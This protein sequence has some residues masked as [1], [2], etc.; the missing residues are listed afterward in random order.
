M[1]KYLYTKYILTY[2]RRNERETGL[3]RH[4]RRSNLKTQVSLWKPMKCFPSS[5]SNRNLKTQQSPVILD[6]CLRKTRSERSRDYHDANHCRNALFS[7]LILSTRKRKADVFEFLRSE[8][9]FRKAPFLWRISVW[10][11]GIWLQK[12]RRNKAANCWRWAVRW[13]A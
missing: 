11:E 6:L 3:I 8:E 1:H 5:L 4:M 10:T 13:R 12:Y 2:T 7:K 9:R